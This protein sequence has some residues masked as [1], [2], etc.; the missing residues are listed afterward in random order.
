MSLGNRSKSKDLY[1]RVRIVE[2]NVRKR[3]LNAR[4]KKSE[5]QKMNSGPYFANCLE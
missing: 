5:P 1:N 2:E 3:R 4:F